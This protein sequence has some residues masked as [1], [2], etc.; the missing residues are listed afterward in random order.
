MVHD[1]LNGNLLSMG[2]WHNWQEAEWGEETTTKSR[3]LS[4][5]HFPY[6][7]CKPPSVNPAT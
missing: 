6:F 1:Q 4:S 5:L 3:F 2:G 7:F